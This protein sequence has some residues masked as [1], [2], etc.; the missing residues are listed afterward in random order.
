MEANRYLS[1]TVLFNDVPA[2]C[3]CRGNR[4]VQSSVPR[5]LTGMLP[6]LYGPEGGVG[7]MPIFL[8]GGKNETPVIRPK[9]RCYSE[10]RPAGSSWVDL[11][12]C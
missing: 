5:T 9:G 1:R 8:A 10:T 2:A 3:N 7:K 12:F 6:A 11:R 4:N